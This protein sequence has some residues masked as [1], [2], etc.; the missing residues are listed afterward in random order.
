M[1]RRPVPIS[2]LKQHL[3]ESVQEMKN[4]AV[5]FDNAN[6]W[7]AKRLA[8]ILALLVDSGRS[9][10]GLLNQLGLHTRRYLTSC[11]GPIRWDETRTDLEIAEGLLIEGY[12]PALDKAKLSF[13]DLDDWW[14]EPVLKRDGSKYTRRD[15]VRTVR[16][17][18]GGA[19]I[20]PTVSETYH[21]LKREQ[22]V[23][24]RPVG[25]SGLYIVDATF[26]NPA[27]F[28]VRQV[29][30]EMLKSLDPTYTRQPK[31]RP[32]DHVI[33]WSHAVLRASA[34]S[35]RA[36]YRETDGAA[37][38]PCDSGVLFALCHQRS[39]A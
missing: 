8:T 34:H 25:H 22:A 32:K 5:S 31:P 26:R 33:I 18:D 4:A 15:I 3:D 29:A 23:I 12:R 28:L 27:R 35:D 21:E 16:D 13:L 37:L 39:K 11:S 24:A 1:S 10:S 2:D 38:C 20:D 6:D 14:S 36:D 30:H 19:H 7:E 9:S 17:Q